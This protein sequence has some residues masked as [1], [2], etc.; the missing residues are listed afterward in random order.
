MLSPR[1]EFTWG[2]KV[3][4]ILIADSSKA[5]LVMTSEVFKDHYPGVQV[6]VA[7]SSSEALELAKHNDGVDAFIIDYDL[8][9]AD[10][11]QTA[12]RLKK[13]YS[14]PVLITAFDR[15]EVAKSIESSLKQYAD[16]QSWLKKPVNPE[17]VIAVVQRFCDGKIRAQKRIPCHLPVFAE[18]LLENESLEAYQQIISPIKAKKVVSKSSSKAENKKESKNAK[19]IK[20][21]LPKKSDSKPVPIYFCG[22]VEDCSLSGVK[23]KPSKNNK[24]G[25]TDWN[26]LLASM[27]FISSGSFVTLKLPSPSDIENG[28]MLE[29]AKILFTPNDHEKRLVSEGTVRKKGAVKAVEST[30]G[31]AS[32]KNAPAL[33]TLTETTKKKATEKDLGDRIQS[34]TGKVAWTSAESGEWC[35][36]VEFENPNLSKRLFEAILSFQLKQQKNSTNQSVM[37]TSR[38]G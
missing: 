25:L 16:C 11:A 8:P 6:L 7:R 29:L 21:K 22:V 35:V 3:K 15:P 33:S 20:K 26:H 5:S 36:G 37:K 31:K 14:T 10:G 30:K 23:L 24:L 28:S 38:A 12:F 2:T 13:L 18:I 19:S 32:Q 27:E 17:V 4:K 1:W 34:L 9:D